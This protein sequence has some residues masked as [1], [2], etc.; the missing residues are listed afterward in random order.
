MASVYDVAKYILECSGEV[1][2]MK[3]QKLAYYSQAWTLVWDEELLFEEEI[4]AWVNGSVI[5]A[6]YQTHRGMF[7]VSKEN[8]NHGDSGDLTESQ[9]DN[10][11]RV[12][13]AYGEYTGQQLSDINHQ[14]DPWLKARE[15]APANARCETVITPASI[16]EYHS[17]IFNAG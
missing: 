4:Q 9:K 3:L 2:A 13:A 16:H 7:K 8:Y 14:E 17:G 6:L 1:T 11:N 15:G 10:I 5:P 12:L